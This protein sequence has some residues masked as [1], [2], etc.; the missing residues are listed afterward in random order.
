MYIYKVDN[1]YIRL[2]ESLVDSRKGARKSTYS[3]YRTLLCTSSINGQSNQ[4]KV[5]NTKLKHLC[6]DA[7]TTTRPHPA[8]QG[9]G[10]E[11][12]TRPHP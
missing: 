9:A 3:A 4:S 8:T 7:S 5:T 12:S 11:T 10:G 2:E 6:S 1:P